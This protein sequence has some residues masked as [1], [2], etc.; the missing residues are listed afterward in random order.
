MFKFLEFLAGIFLVAGFIDWR[1]KKNS[2]ELKSNN[3]GARPGEDANYLAGD[4][5]YSSWS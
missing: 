5:R 3:Q 2:H 1:R 4:N